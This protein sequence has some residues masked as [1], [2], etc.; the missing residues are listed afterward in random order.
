MINIELLRT[1]IINIRLPITLPIKLPPLNKELEYYRL[2]NGFKDANDE[3]KK[4]YIK[5]L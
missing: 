4:K 3:F 5:L 1:G 2:S